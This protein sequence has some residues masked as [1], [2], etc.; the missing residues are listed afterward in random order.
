MGMG[1][2]SGR[3]EDQ[4]HS[5]PPAPRPIAAGFEGRGFLTLA[6]S[7]YRTVQPS[8]SRRALWMAVAA[9]AASAVA[10][11]IWFRPRTTS[12]AA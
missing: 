10:T 6:S 7:R 9:T 1:R 12:P 3:L 4:P 11:A 2:G 5:P 8:C